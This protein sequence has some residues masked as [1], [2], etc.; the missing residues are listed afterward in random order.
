MGEL[1]EANELF[2]KKKFVDAIKK[3]ELIYKLNRII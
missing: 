1:D 3:Y 2:L